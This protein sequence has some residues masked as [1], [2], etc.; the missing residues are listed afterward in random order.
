MNTIGITGGTGFVGQYLMRL[1]L[2]KGYKVTIFSTGKEL[3]PNNGPLR[4]A[5]WDPVKRVIDAR[6]LAA[7]DGMVH[8][9]GAG[10]ADKR[11]TAAR[12]QLIAD[13]RI[14]GTEFIVSQLRNA[15]KH[16]QA[17]ISASAIG[18]YGPD[19]GT[20][21][22]TEDAPASPDFLGNTCRLWE[23]EAKKASAFTRTA[24]LRLGIVL[25]AESGAFPQFAQP[26]SFG[27][28]P[29]LGPGS[30]VVSWIA[31][32]DLARL[33]LHALQNDQMTGIF[34]AVAP[35]PVS[36]KEL[37]K[38]IASVKGGISLPAPAPA[39]MLRLM[40]GEMSIEVLK[41]CTVSAD[42]TLAT[43]FRFQYPL[44]RKAVA[45]ILKKG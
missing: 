12:K 7:V 22:F 5:S 11:W 40:L 19:R 4:Y 23:E 32:Q 14:K 44:L 37:M 33:F 28:M 15:G 17:F 21:P 25:G 6:A 45:V 36:E 3:K 27:V 24:I 18:F 13:S 39:F 1:L 26:L 38:T 20:G 34:N 8:L 9:A 31:V 10:I 42:K 16:C 41:S 29:I 35:T 30:Q 43:G 2:E